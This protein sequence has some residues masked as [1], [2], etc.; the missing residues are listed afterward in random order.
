MSATTDLAT[1]AV[2]PAAFRANLVIDADGTPRRWAEV[3]DPWQRADF[4]ALDPGLLRAAGRSALLTEPPTG[5]TPLSCFSRV[6]F[7]R[8]RGH[9]KT[10]D[11]AAIVTWALAF[12]F[13]PIRAFAFASDKD[14]AK[15]LLDAITTLIRLNPWLSAIL[16]TQSNA[17]V[18]RAAG[19]PG[20]GARLEVWTSD[21]GS[22]YGIL[23]D[24][25]VCDELC[26]WAGNG[27]LWYSLISSAAKRSTC[28]LA[29]IS[30]AGFSDSWVYRVREA[31]RTDPAW[32]FS[33]QDGPVASWLTGARLE[34]QRRM[35]PEV[36][37]RRLWLNE[38]SSGGG[39]A[40]S[41][42][43]IDAAFAAGAEPW[44]AET[45]HGWAFVGGLDLGLTR[46]GA[47]LVVLATGSTG[48]IRLADHRLWR[49]TLGRKLDLMAVEDHIVAT[50]R[51]FN[52]THIAYDPWQAELMAQRLEALSKKR[53]RDSY[54]SPNPRRQTN[55]PWLR[56]IPPTGN[57]LREQATLVIE[58]FK[59]RRIA[60]SEC[61]PLKRDLLKLRCE[62]K[63]YGVRLVS[64]RDGDGHGDSFSALALALL[65]ANEVSGRKPV[66]AG[67]FGQAT[68][69]PEHALLLGRGTSGM[70]D[71]QRMWRKFLLRAGKGAIRRMG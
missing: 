15:I 16:E 18:N 25:I 35:L 50:D 28:L 48:R 30:N 68:L 57:N 70:T 20:F 62:E 65:V 41:Q 19:H 10:T 23:P 42:E 43:D 61:E 3:M 69:S 66:R 14:Q 71:D 29:V 38:W 67:P 11:I 1:F 56:E 46:D 45:Q 13:R 53:R 7:E 36:A 60:L 33:R 5:P 26:H 63:S 4:A 47:S 2:D 24:L 32:Y 58:T 40:L 6:Y 49:P 27:D 52:L 21:V 54:L 44:D 22:S 59:D 39:D 34:E 51:K 64:P 31:A 12:A 17:V 8:G 9:S 55:L 37:Y